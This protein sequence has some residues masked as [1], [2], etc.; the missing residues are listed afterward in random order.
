MKIADV[1]ISELEYNILQSCFN[2][3]RSLKTVKASQSE[4]NKCKESLISNGL[5]KEITQ[6]LSNNDELVI[7]T[8]SLEVKQ[9]FNNN[10]K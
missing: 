9:Y 5:L 8:L 10:P 7:Y 6:K 3:D 1:E 2:G 4:V